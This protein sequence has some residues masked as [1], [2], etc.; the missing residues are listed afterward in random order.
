MNI[1]FHFLAVLLVLAFFAV[2][3]GG[4]GFFKP[5]CRNDYYVIIASAFAFVFYFLSGQGLFAAA[6]PT[7]IYLCGLLFASPKNNTDEIIIYGVLAVFSAVLAA[8][9]GGHGTLA[10]MFLT[11]SAAVLAVCLS[12]SACDYVNGTDSLISKKIAYLWPVFASAVPGSGGDLFISVFLGVVSTLIF[13]Y[14]ITKLKISEDILK[15]IF[16]VL[17]LMAVFV[18]TIKSNLL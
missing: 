4:T 13:H 7:I 9:Y 14:G 1:I 6:V 12:L 10:A 8:F 11:L 17:S 15:L 2:K 16:F 5:L 3:E 18:I